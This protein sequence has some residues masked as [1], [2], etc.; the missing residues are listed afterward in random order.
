MEDTIKNLLALEPVSDDP[1]EYQKLAELYFAE[2]RRMNE[3]MQ[4]DQKEIDRLTVQ[5]H[6]HLD[7]LRK[8]A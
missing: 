5:I 4:Q 3:K 8:A 2:M 7:R 6:A 1:A